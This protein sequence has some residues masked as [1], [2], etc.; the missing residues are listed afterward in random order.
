MRS[1]QGLVVTSV[2]APE[3]AFEATADNV[4]C[5]VA[6]VVALEEPAQ[7][8]AFTGQ[9]NAVT[10]RPGP[11][12]GAAGPPTCDDDASRAYRQ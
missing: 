10:P 9:K 4:S 5:I 12:A 11:C 8:W 7:V 2:H 3:S 6:D 1:G